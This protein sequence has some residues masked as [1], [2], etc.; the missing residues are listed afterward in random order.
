MSFGKW[1][2][3]AA[4]LVAA[5]QLWKMHERSVVNRKLLPLEDTNGFVP[6]QTPAGTAPNTVLILAAVNCPSAAAQRADTMAKQLSDMHIPSSRA[7]SYSLAITRREQL[8]LLQQTS[9][10][11][12]GE[13]P[14]VIV[15][16][17]AKA[18]PTVDEVASEYRRSQ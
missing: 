11:L 1:L 4:L 17:M 2:L 9:L 15:N 16:G 7:N 6:V 10:V 18:N 3:L 5:P 12:G 8:P 14:V 13:I